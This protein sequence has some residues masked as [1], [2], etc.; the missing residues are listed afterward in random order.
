MGGMIEKEELG[1]LLASLGEALSMED[2]DALFEAMDDDNSGG[3]DFEEFKRLMVV[4]N[5][6][7]N[8]DENESST[9]WEYEEASHSSY[10]Y[11]TDSEQEVIVE[12]YEP[13]FDIIDALS[14]KEEKKKNANNV[15]FNL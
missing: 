8:E 11:I 15:Q 12:E 6:V 14:S 9:S 3:I 4:L 2:L 1:A 13:E 5:A 7:Q 10:E